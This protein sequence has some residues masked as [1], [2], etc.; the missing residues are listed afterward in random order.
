MKWCKHLS[1]VAIGVGLEVTKTTLM[2]QLIDLGNDSDGNVRLAAIETVVKLLDFLDTESCAQ[3]VVPLVIECC[4]RA[5]TNQEDHVLAKLAH[6]HGQLCHGL[7]TTLDEGKRHWFLDFYKFLAKQGLSESKSQQMSDQPMPDLLPVQTTESEDKA[8]IRTRCRYKCA[9]N[10]PAMVLFVGA[11][12]FKDVLYK[13]FSDLTKDPCALVRATVASSLHELAKILDAASFN[14]TK[15]QISD[16]FGDNDIVVLES[17][18]GN[19]VHVIDA[20]ARFGVFAVW[21]RGKV[22]LRPECCPGPL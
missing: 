6:F 2:P 4:D 7:A 5:R 12:D 11:P 8:E 13:T 1:Q 19:M 14:L 21:P 15:T 9:Y 3:T 22:Q 16:L 20:L 18:V 10:F 17:M